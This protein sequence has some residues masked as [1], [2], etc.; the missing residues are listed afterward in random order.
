MEE[1]YGCQLI[2]RSNRGIRLTPEGEKLYDSIR[3]AIEQL[4]FAENRIYNLTNLQQGLV[5]VGASDTGLHGILIPSL[6]QFRE[7]HPQIRVR[8]SSSF[9]A[10]TVQAVKN[11][12]YDFAIL[13]T[14][15]V[16]DPALTYTPIM[17]FHDILLA[18][19]AFR[20]LADREYSLRELTQYP[21]VCH[22]EHS[23]SFTF[24]KTFYYSLGVPFAPDIMAVTT[25]QALLMVQ[26]NL[27]I[28]F[29][30]DLYVRDALA[31][32]SVFE[33][34]LKEKIPVRTFSLV[35]NR[36]TSMNLAAKE[37]KRVILAGEHP[38]PVSPAHPCRE[39]E[40]PL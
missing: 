5:H 20:F 2:L 15:A 22:D 23:P 33:I 9:Y 37:L 34:K 32:H 4:Q 31:S 40:N 17:H 3:P 30:P 39:E 10:D 13:A 16:E 12:L 35:E 6:N 14:P 28:A 29:L 8:I 38:G 7:L 27:G 26:N 24:Y 18:G 1:E 25:P 11:A 21:L 36:H 19:P